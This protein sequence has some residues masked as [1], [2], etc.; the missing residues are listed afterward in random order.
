MFRMN[1]LIDNEHEH[2]IAFDR[3]K[4]SQRYTIQE[5]MSFLLNDLYPIDMV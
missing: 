3:N 4:K 2:S 1:S 5:T